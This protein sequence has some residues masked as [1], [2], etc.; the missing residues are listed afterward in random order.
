[1]NGKDTVITNPQTKET[2]PFAFDYSYWS[3]DGFTEGDDGYLNPDP[4]SNYSSQRVVFEDLGMG[5]LNNAYE[6]YNTSLFAYGQTGSGKSYSMIGYGSNKG[7]VPIT[8]DELF[9]KISGNTDD[10]KFEV[11]FSMLEIYNEQVR[12]LLCKTN[13]KGGLPVRENPKLG[14]FYVGDLKKVA[15]GSYAEIER[16]IEEGNS[17]RT[18]ASTQMNATSSRAHTVVT[19]EFVQKKMQDGKEMAKE[20]IENFYGSLL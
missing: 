20:R 5:V 19:I 2:K 15:V 11:K 12:D 9:K 14:L 3:H 16:R 6:G 13:P 8:C 1:M 18:V 4:G 10:T 7:I 17:N